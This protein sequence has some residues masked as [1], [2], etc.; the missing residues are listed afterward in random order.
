MKISV[1]V[2]NLTPIHSSDP[3]QAKITV[4]GKIVPA[5]ERVGF[6]FVRMRTINIPVSYG[7]G[8]A[9]MAPM[10]CVP[11]NTMRNLLRRAALEDVLRPLF[12][13]SSMGIGAYA[14]AFAGN[15]TGN[16]EGQASTFDETIKIRQ[17]CFLGLFGGGPRFHHGRLSVDNMYPITE[18]AV[19]IIGAGYE[20][21]YVGGD[22]MST[23]WI[24]RSDPITKIND[25]E[26]ASVIAN[27]NEA[28][29]SWCLA[30]NEKPKKGNKASE[31]SEE[32]T[33]TDKNRGLNAFNAHEVVSPGVDWLWSMRLKNP[34][35]AQVGLVLKSI[36]NIVDLDMQVAGGNARDYGKISIEDVLVDGKSVWDSHGFDESMNIY[37]DD[38][39]EELDAITAKDFEDFV[40]QAEKK[41]SAKDVA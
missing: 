20:D 17:H 3:V 38:L 12:G 39:A 34:T 16:P 9:T 2:R 5:T 8:A 27:G 15:A 29:T 30:M 14:A 32:G 24:R 21:R 35:N 11:Q 40:K 4:E 36:R 33:E 1:I 41:P 6:P 7:E 37:F 10:P 28:I 18:K 23:V 22:I 25:P 26:K 31:S 19:R 13:T